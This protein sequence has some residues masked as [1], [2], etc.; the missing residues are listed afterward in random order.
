MR[1]TML[2]PRLAPGSMP[3]LPPP[4]GSGPPCSRARPRPALR[5]LLLTDSV[6]VTVGG[7][8]MRR[9]L[10]AG[11][12][13]IA[14]IGSAGSGAALAQAQPLVLRVVPSADLTELDPTRG[15]N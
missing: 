2:W 6:R 14:L 12:A 5:R 13:T 15:A 7:A 11:L 9:W 1:S 3:S 10:L 4:P 8:V